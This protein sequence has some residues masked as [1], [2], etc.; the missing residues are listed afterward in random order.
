MV[1]KSPDGIPLEIIGGKRPKGLF[2]SREITIS[3]LD[4]GIEEV[5]VRPYNEMGALDLHAI[6]EAA[7]D[8]TQLR[9]ESLCSSNGYDV[10]W[11][12]FAADTSLES[13]ALDFYGHTAMFHY[14]LVYYLWE[15]DLK[16]ADK[17]SIFQCRCSQDLRLW[18][19]AGGCQPI[20]NS[21]QSSS[22]LKRNQVKPTEK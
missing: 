16:S 3:V 6:L 18:T 5:S 1:Q 14:W 20:L 2:R 22:T 15:L 11:K 8:H 4:V 7:V 19:T 21:M 10:L 9:S 13:P 12:T 17:F